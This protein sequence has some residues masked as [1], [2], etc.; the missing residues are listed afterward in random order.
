MN[1]LELATKVAAQTEGKSDRFLLICVVVLA[2][3]FLGSMVL[4]LARY[5]REL[6]ADNKAMHVEMIKVLTANNESSKNIVA[7]LDRIDRARK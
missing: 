4:C 2:F 7:T 1:H 6:I 5:L 3:I